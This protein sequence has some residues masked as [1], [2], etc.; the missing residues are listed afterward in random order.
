MPPLN[1]PHPDA[2]AQQQFLTYLET[3]LDRAAATH[4]NPGRA[5]IHRLNRAEY[6]NAVRD[7]FSLDVR[8]GNTLPLDDTGYGFDNIGDVLSLS[9]VLLERYLTASRMV[10]RLAVADTDL[11]PE[12][13]SFDLGR[14]R[15]ARNEAVSEDLP[16]GSG[17]G[18]SFTYTFPVD[19]DYTFKVR[20]PAPAPGFGETAAPVGQ[21]LELKVPVKAGVRHVG[22]SFMRSNAV[23]ETLP[24]FGNGRG[25]GGAGVGRGGAPGASMAHLDLRVDGARLKMW[26]VPE[27]PNGPRFNDLSIGGPYDVKQQSESASRKIIFGVC[28]P[29][30]PKE[31]DVCARKT[32]TA[33][34][35]RAYRRPVTDSDIKP[36]MTFYASGRKEKSYEYG[37]ETALRAMLVAPDFLFRVERDPASSAAASH[38]VNDFE[39]ASRLSFFLWSSIPDEEL[40]SLADQGKLRDQKMVESQIA[41]MLDDPKS[42]A[43]V[44]NFSGQ[45]LFLRNLDQVK[46]DP[47]VFP[48]FDASLKKSFQ[49]ETE[50]F[51]NS[52]LREERPVSE[53]LDAKYTFMNQRLAEFYGVKGVFGPQFRRVELTDPRRGGLLG[54]GSILTVTSYPNRTSVVQRGK[55]ILENLLGTPPPAPP[56][57]V[58]PLDTHGKEGKLTMRQAMEAH[59]ANPVCASCHS[60][61]DPLGFALENYDGIGQWRDTDGGADIDPSG[62]LPNG[63][64]F[65]GG[66]GLRQA[67]LNNHREE[68]VS[69]FTE[70]LMIYALGR[71]L[72]PYDRPVM[73]SIM[74]EAARHNTTIPALINAIIQSPQFQMRR[75]RES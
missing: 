4:P 15:G 30:G 49:Q 28:R 48:Q 34:A 47:D 1:V 39:L 17:L 26:D 9:P 8:A 7:L 46:P 45:W 23:P 24:V 61:M 50:L 74:R 41:R 18:L 70:K 67:L 29:G 44:S 6:S 27:G 72:E 14:G 25:G 32:L 11:K 13:N 20:L 38:R 59:R 31:E 21:V 64:S 10:S 5:T 60:K 22:I 65:K 62:T 42:K 16:F 52:I 40:L 19:A 71:G 43:F 55:W 56:P 54:Q 68:F 75:N 69:T 37:I 73:R 36:L 33:L 3:E 57:N 51:F 12:I 35:R 53:F 58:P 66:A 63:A 2:A